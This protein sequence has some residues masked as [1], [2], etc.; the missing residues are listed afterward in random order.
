MFRDSQKNRQA[1]GRE[2]KKQMGEEEEEE[3]EKLFSNE[4][5]R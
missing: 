4:N 3:D 5:S 1:V 2:S